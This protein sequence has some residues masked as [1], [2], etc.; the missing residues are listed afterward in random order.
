[1]ESIIRSDD[2]QKLT[3]ADFYA[4]IQK[5]KDCPEFY[6][7][8]N[9]LVGANEYLIME[10]LGKGRVGFVFLAY[11]KRK[12]TALKMSYE[13]QEDE[14]IFS[15]VKK[16]VGDDYREYFLRPVGKAVKIVFF[17]LGS[18]EEGSKDF[19]DRDVFVSFWEPADATL[20]DKLDE[21][22]ENKLKWFQYFLKGLSMIHSRDRA[23]FDIKLENLFLVGDQL[24]IGD[25]DFYA[26]IDDFKKSGIL[27]G[28]PGHIAPEMFYDRESI[29]PKVDIFSAG[30]AF[31]R[32]FTGK[33]F[34]QESAL[35]LNLQEEQEMEKYFKHDSAHHSFGN[36]DF[37]LNYKIFRFYQNQLHDKSASR[38]L[39]AD[40][41]SIYHLL[42]KMIDIDPAG[43]PTVNEI[44]SRLGI[45]PVFSAPLAESEHREPGAPH[46][47]ENNIS[48]FVRML[49]THDRRE[50]IKYCLVPDLLEKLKEDRVKEKIMG[51]Q[52][53]G[54][55]YEKRFFSFTVL[56]T[57]TAVRLFGK[58]ITSKE[59]KKHKDWNLLVIVDYWNRWF[60]LGLEKACD[61]EYIK[62]LLDGKTLDELD[63][64]IFQSKIKSTKRTVLKLSKKIREAK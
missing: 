29:T 27:C 55:S 37:R 51:V 30:I 53:K 46:R 28:T 14:S 49:R 2:R 23:H 31:V 4:N 13:D 3:L 19:F 34:K 62:K 5:G 6:R 8:A 40:E 60:Q 48:P 43:R 20:S 17:Y 47:Q 21:S 45:T 10:V 61:R 9:L 52:F 22:F 12:L 24:K 57:E 15:T 38:Q 63:Q 7:K 39:T 50:V 35:L 16:T 32:L 58:K 1:M 42:L 59:I 36:Y 18:I 33:D 54:D 26:K 25:F 64:G 11:H 44:L 56:K 41:K